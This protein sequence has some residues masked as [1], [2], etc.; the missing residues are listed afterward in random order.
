MGAVTVAI[1]ADG[2]EPG[3]DLFLTHEFPTAEQAGS[4]AHDPALRA[5]MQA[6]G[7]EGAPQVPHAGMERRVPRGPGRAQPRSCRGR[8]RPG[9]D[10]SFTGPRSCPAARNVPGTWPRTAFVS[11]HRRT[12]APR[13]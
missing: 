4:S 12:A 10:L 6:A 2:E 5:G 9:H 3:N 13:T 1:T 7:V 8:P 11:F